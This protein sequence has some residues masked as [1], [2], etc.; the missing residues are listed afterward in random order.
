VTRRLAIGLLAIGLVL[1]GSGA[2]ANDAKRSIE[3]SVGVDG[4]CEVR[5]GDQVFAGT[6]E[7][8]INR[9]P[10][11]FPNRKKSLRL[12]DNNGNVPYRCFVPL[13]RIL[14][15]LDYSE[16]TLETTPPPLNTDFSIPDLDPAPR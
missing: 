13:L 2:A 15:K 9:L 5:I 1:Q 10:V 7:E 14:R 11:L 6:A 16:V 4:S 8:L 3:L 12:S